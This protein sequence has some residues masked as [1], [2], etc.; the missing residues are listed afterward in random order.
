MWFGAT[1]VNEPAP[2]PENSP[3]AASLAAMALAPA[4]ASTF[5]VLS[6]L[7]LLNCVAMAAY[8]QPGSPKHA[9]VFRPRMGLP[10]LHARRAG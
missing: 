8:Q 3:A 7:M 1:L 2:Q 4:T 10:Q 6:S 5:S 9:A